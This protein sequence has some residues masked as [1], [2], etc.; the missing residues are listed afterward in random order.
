[1]ASPSGA[2]ATGAAW[3]DARTVASGAARSAASVPAVAARAN[4]LERDALGVAGSRARIANGRRAAKRR[5]D[6]ALSIRRWRPQPT[7]RDS[8]T[9]M[10][11]PQRMRGPGPRNDGLAGARRAS[12]PGR[13]ESC[14]RTNRDFVR[15][16]P[17]ESPS[18][19][20]PRPRSPRRSSFMR[21]GRSMREPNLYP[22]AKACRRHARISATAIRC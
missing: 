11:V 20:L 5:R 22:H 16:S 17:R 15:S 10:I 6:P 12:R 4:R 8:G 19:P 13:V 9:G 21:T 1:M 7:G 3:G 14:R 2:A 18:G